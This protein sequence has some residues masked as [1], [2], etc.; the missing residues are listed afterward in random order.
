MDKKG[1]FIQMPV[2]LTNKVVEVSQLQGNR[3]FS[4]IYR[5]A[6]ESYCERALKNKPIEI[7]KQN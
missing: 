5:E 7:L 3:S 1:I 2:S 4:S 6:V